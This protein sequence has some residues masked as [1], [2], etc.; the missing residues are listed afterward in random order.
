MLLVDDNNLLPLL[1]YGFVQFTSD[2][3]LIPIINMK[4]LYSSCFPFFFFRGDGGIWKYIEHYGL[5]TLVLYLHLLFIDKLHTHSMG[6]DD[7]TLHI[8]L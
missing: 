1:S 3:W 4:L 6:F 8:A 7:L 2:F 5:I